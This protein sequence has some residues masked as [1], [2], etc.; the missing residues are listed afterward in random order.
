MSARKH[1]RLLSMSAFNG[2]LAIRS[3]AAANPSVP[4]DDLIWT[5]RRVFPDDGYH[6]YEAALI[7]HNRITKEV[8]HSNIPAFFRNT[9]TDLIQQEKP[10]WLRFAPLGRGRLRSALSSNEEQCFEAAEL[11]SGMPDSAALDWWDSLAQSVRADEDSKR[12]LQGREAE[13]LTIAYETERLSSLGITTPPR[14]IALDDNSAGYDVHSFDEGPVVPIAKL[15]EVK[16]CSSQ[17]YE[18]FLTKNEWETALERAPR[19]RFHVWILPEQQLIELAP[20]DLSNHVPQDR[21]N[22]LW[23][24]VRITLPS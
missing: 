17:P 6:D 23:Q 16:S 11:F 18:I 20:G 4:L 14:W 12:L 22:G 2:L 21:G 7:L 8:G 1:E 13:Q 19:Y 24:I 15:I 3:Y 9:L 5:I 10:W